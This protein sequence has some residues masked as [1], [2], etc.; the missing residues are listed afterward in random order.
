MEVVNIVILAMNLIIP[1][2]MIIIG[3]ATKNHVPKNRYGAVGYRT[4][5]SRSSQE[6]WEY[7]NKECSKLM[8]KLG[9]I[10]LLVSVIVSLPFLK[11]TEVV[12]SVVCTVVVILQCVVLCVG[13]LGIEKKLAEKFH[14]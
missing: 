3:L 1:V 12:V 8:L 11:S 9:L 6:A 7:A 2:V 14:E 4:K 10:I 13:F 5:R